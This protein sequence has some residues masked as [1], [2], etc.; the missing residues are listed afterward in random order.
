[1]SPKTAKKHSTLI[2][3]AVTSSSAAICAEDS[4]Q[5]TVNL[6]PADA[7]ASDSH[8]EDPSVITVAD[9]QAPPCDADQRPID[10][11][12]DNG[13]TSDY[14]TNAGGY[15]DGIATATCAADA[16]TEIAEPSDLVVVVDASSGTEEP[17]HGNEVQPDATSANHEVTE[18]H[19]SA[20]SAS[21][22]SS[23]A[24][25][26]SVG[27]PESSAS[28]DGASL[29]TLPDPTSIS[30]RL[31]NLV[32]SVSQVEELSRRA[33]EVAASDLAL[34]NGIAASRCQF[35]EG[36]DEARRIGQEAKA[37]YQRAFGRD[38]KALAEP[39]VAE[40][41]DVEQAFGDLAGAWRQ[42]AET[43]LAE[44]PD[45]EALIAEQRHHDDE[46]RRRD[47][48]RA[49]AERFQQLVLATDAALRQ[50]LLD[51]ARDCIKLLGR[52]F[53]AEAA[54]VAPLQERLD[55]RT[56]AANDAAARRVLLEASELQGRG[57]FNAAV[58]LL[59][60][61]EVQ[62]LSRETSEDV[63]GRWSAACSLLGQSGGLELLRSSSSQGRGII[64]H[65][66][67]TV[68]YGLVVFSALGMGPTYFEG[69]IVS[70]A[71][72]DGA[73]MIGRARPFRAAEL[74]PELGAGWYGRSYVTS[75]TAGAPVRH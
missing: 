3:D 42:Q 23:D 41:R 7:T 62:S 13:V 35:E 12:A 51:D 46:A 68:P 45:V 73:A 14:H 10:G 56:R 22:P 44:H 17:L 8:P 55:H 1:M 64:L 21:D 60:A 72:R 59:E 4:M 31:K 29:P 37:V 6:I 11:V 75:S 28:D 36:L 67:P 52:E 34:Y 24:T 58:K 18:S 39:A 63:F 30:A 74:P 50:G 53:P 33:R 19:A 27:P 49:K 71:D 66:D 25:A 65:H 40:A 16:L 38:A 48:A 26:V 47:V 5:A 57:D 15:V 32:V 2:D 9:G 20:P 70:A 69:R 43:F 61:V 54:R